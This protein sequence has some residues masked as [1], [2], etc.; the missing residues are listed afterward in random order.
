MNLHGAIE[1]LEL[2]GVCSDGNCEGNNHS[3]PNAAGNMSHR[4]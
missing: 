2:L 1:E 3:C 4:V